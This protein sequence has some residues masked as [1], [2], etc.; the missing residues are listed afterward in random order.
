M[1]IYEPDSR[2]AFQGV[3]GPVRP[4]GDYVFRDAD[5]ATKVTFSL[6]APMSGFKSLF[7]GNAVQKAMDSEVAGLDRAKSVL[8]SGT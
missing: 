5:K 6:D 1:T 2:V 8:E 4:R 7:M 3:A